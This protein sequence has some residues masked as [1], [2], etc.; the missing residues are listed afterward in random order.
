[1]S[2]KNW[3]KYFLSTGKPE[4]T[5]I[6]WSPGAESGRSSPAAA[7]ERFEEMS[8]PPSSPKATKNIIA[9]SYAAAGKSRR[10]RGRKSRK[11]SRRT[12]RR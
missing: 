6:G 11:A 1:M 10:R 12:R 7:L 8:T 4:N 3:A 5:E 2:Q 9:T